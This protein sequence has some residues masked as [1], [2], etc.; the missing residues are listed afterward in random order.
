MLVTRQDGTNNPVIDRPII[1]RY[2]ITLRDAAGAVVDS[3]TLWSNN[4]VIMRSF[5][6]TPYL[7]V[8][9]VLPN[10]VSVAQLRARDTMVRYV[11]LSTATSTTGTW[12]VSEHAWHRGG[13]LARAVW[14][15]HA[16][17]SNDAHTPLYH[18]P[19]LRL[20]SRAPLPN[21]V[22]NRSTSRR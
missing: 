3:R 20:S 4:T 15:G 11:R 12:L 18:T 2:N 19:P 9:Q 14:R 17:R 10:P 16:A 21:R 6:S 1:N 8:A 5:P 13:R 7:P 22:P